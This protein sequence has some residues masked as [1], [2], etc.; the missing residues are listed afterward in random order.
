MASDEQIE[1]ACEALLELS[2]RPRERSGENPLAVVIRA[3]IEAAERKAPLTPGMRLAP[4]QVDY[5]RYQLCAA[6]DHATEGNAS[7][8]ADVCH[9]T[10][11]TL[12]GK[13]CLPP[14]LPENGDEGRG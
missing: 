12:F 4:H 3:I 14:A 1:A 6:R 10:Y 8:A 5:L 2:R 11:E 9:Y 13:R 7:L